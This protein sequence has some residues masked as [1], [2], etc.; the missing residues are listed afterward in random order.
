MAPLF[1]IH[2]ELSE[3]GLV[4]SPSLEVGDDSGFLALIESLINDIYNVAKLIPRLARGRVNYKVSPPLP[5]LGP[6]GFPGSELPPSSAVPITSPSPST[7][8]GSECHQGPRDWV[9]LPSPLPKPRPSS[10]SGPSSVGLACVP[11]AC[12]PPGDAQR[13][14]WPLPG[15][16]LPRVPSAPGTLTL[17]TPPLPA[18]GL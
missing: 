15:V 17:V 13:V 18:H 6:C 1:E 2:M 10:S 8:R 3:G 14:P 16:C 7:W 4:F 9:G 11:D 12:P 5:A